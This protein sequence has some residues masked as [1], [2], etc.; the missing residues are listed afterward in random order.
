MMRQIILGVA[1]ATYLSGCGPRPDSARHDTHETRFPD[2]SRVVSH[3]RDGL[4]EGR[5]ILYDP[6]GYIRG[7]RYYLHD[8]LNGPQYLF[9]PNG[10]PQV[11]ESTRKGKLNGFS[12]EFYPN[13]RLASTR[14]LV[15]GL[16]T[17]PFR[18][19]FN[20]HPSRLR[21]ATDYVI[22]A[23][24]EYA[25]YSARYDSLGRLVLRTGRLLARAD[26]DTVALGDTLVLRLRIE[27]PM[28]Q[29]SGLSTGDYDAQFVLRTSASEQRVGGLHHGVTLRIPTATPGADT[30][31]GYMDDFDETGPTSRKGEVAVKGR[32]MYFAY[33]YLVQ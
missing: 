5:V 4:V 32:K 24:R 30:V 31:R 16:R 1:A 3:K 9:Y 17:G 11:C 6:T 22:V 7:I 20:T 18:A 13:G 23:G 10:R 33:P 26:H 19:Y 28:H 25:N 8:T 21:E 12:C 29:Q 27:H 14:Y 15:D 2:G